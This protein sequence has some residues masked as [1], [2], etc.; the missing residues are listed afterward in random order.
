MSLYEYKVVP[1]PS[2]GLKAKGIKTAQDRFAHAL[3]AVMN[4]MGA[5][6]WEYQRADTLPSEERS[7]LTGRVTSFQHM[8]VFRRALEEDQPVLPVVAPVVAAPAVVAPAEVEEDVEPAAEEE[9]QSA[10]DRI[11]ET[12][13]PEG[14]ATPKVEAKP[15]EDD[16]TRTEPRISAQ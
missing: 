3:E 7:G 12:L 10:Q 11:A 15:L 5:Q 8:L 2:K 16:P 14:E 9:V 4:E 1:A 6:G 13:A